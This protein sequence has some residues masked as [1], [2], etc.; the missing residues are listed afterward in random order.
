MAGRSVQH[1]ALSFGFGF[2]F[3][4]QVGSESDALAHEAPASDGGLLS[5]YPLR[6]RS[7][8]GSD[9]RYDDQGDANDVR[10]NSEKRAPRI[11]PFKLSEVTGRED[12]RNNREVT[13]RKETVAAETNRGTFNVPSVRAAPP[14]A[15]EF[16][17]AMNALLSRKELKECLAPSINSAGQ[18]KQQLKEGQR[19]EEEHHS[20]KE[21]VGTFVS[22]ITDTTGLGDIDLESSFST[23]SEDLK[24]ACGNRTVVAGVVE[25][26]REI[27][28]NGDLIDEARR[29]LHAQHQPDAALTGMSLQDTGKSALAE[30]VTES[31]DDMDAIVVPLSRSPTLTSG[32]S[33]R[34]S[35]A[36]SRRRMEWDRLVDD[37][38]CGICRD[39]LACPNLTDCTHSFCGSCIEA[40]YDNQAARH[41]GTPHAP[42]PICRA[43]ISTST[44]ERVLDRDIARKVEGWLQSERGGGACGL[45]VEWRRRR[46][47]FHALQ[48]ERKA[49]GAAVSLAARRAQV[50]QERLSSMPFYDRIFGDHDDDEE[51]L[52]EELDRLCEAAAELVIPL[53]CAVVVIVIAMR[54]G[55][56]KGGAA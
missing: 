47:A 23:L 46:E 13:Q 2:G 28:S 11:V 37:Y 18:R 19:E 7:L 39:L 21:S 25:V 44:F 12:R 8:S 42:C 6:R 17:V 49:N 43:D 16:D 26:V 30:E 15:A 33:S 10:E 31:D 56:G 41:T 4:R 50:R 24:S 45:V 20:D 36:D 22:S 48:L 54:N 5:P 27:V 34:S 29:Q 14:D 53:V 38:Q 52:E 51:E 40:Y 1:L 35:G 32:P 3:A 9:Q 55:R